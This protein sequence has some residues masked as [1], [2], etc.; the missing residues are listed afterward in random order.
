[1]VVPVSAWIGLPLAAL[2]VIALGCIRAHR[3]WRGE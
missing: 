1:V 2:L 3:L